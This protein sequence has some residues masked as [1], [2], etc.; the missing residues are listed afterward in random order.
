MAQEQSLVLGE[1]ST[2][3]NRMVWAPAVPMPETCRAA[4]AAAK[5]RQSCLTLHDPMDCSLPGC[6][7]HGISQ[8]RVLEWG[9]IASPDT[10]GDRGTKT[11]TFERYDNASLIWC[12]SIIKGFPRG[13]GGKESACNAGDPGWIPESRRSPGEGTLP[14]PVLLPGNPMDRGAWPAT[15]HGV[16]NSWTWLSN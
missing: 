8:A 12:P 4:A 9:A 16:T 3:E 7:I 13:S 11:F 10:S 2:L 5:S 14:T 1:R 15:V 6:S